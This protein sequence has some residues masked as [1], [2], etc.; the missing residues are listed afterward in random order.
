MLLSLPGVRGINTVLA[1][2]ERE[3]HVV[4]KWGFR[5]EIEQ[6]HFILFDKGRELPHLK[7]S[8]PFGPC[9]DIYLTECNNGG[10]ANWIWTSHETEGAGRLWL[11][12]QMCSMR[13]GRS[14]P[15]W[16]KDHQ[17]SAARWRGRWCHGNLEIYFSFS[18][19]NEMR[20]EV[21][22]LHRSSWQW[23]CQLL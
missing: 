12:K 7:D 21:S 18:L 4:M 23:G 17:Q 14:M 9:G 1:W 2:V 8:G 20:W 5:E 6:Y 15:C 19:E 10:I 11:V 16:M 13:N 3:S 22:S